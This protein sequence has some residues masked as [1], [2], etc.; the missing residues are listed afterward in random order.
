[1]LTLSLGWSTIYSRDRPKEKSMSDFESTLIAY[2]ET[3]RFSRYDWVLSPASEQRTPEAYPYAYSPYYLF[4]DAPKGS[5][6]IKGATSVYTDRMRDED[7]EKARLAL[8]EFGFCRP[9][10]DV[11]QICKEAAQIFW[12]P[13]VKC[14]GYALGC[15]QSSG[16][17]HGIFF[18]KHPT[19]LDV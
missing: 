12:G 9:K 10:G 15:N 11:R 19:D 7:P 3:G 6:G 14:L 18:L 5:M 17:P 1:M 2:T 8:K 4:R 16:N 13:K